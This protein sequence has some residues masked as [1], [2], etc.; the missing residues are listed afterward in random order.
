MKIAVISAAV[1]NKSGSRAPVEL[2]VHLAKL[3]HQ[4]F[5]FAFNT[6]FEKEA[7]NYL[8]QNK[9]QIFILGSSGICGRWVSANNLF[10]KLRTLNPDILSTHCT[11][12]L[13]VAAWFTG[14][15]VVKTYYGLQFFS[16]NAL[17]LK[18]KLLAG[19]LDK[20]IIL[21][22]KIVFK[23][24]H[25][26]VAISKYL[27]SEAE[28]LLG[29]KIAF[30]YIGVDQMPKPK[31]KD[32][33]LVQIK[34]RGEVLILSVSRI[35]PYK[36]FDVLIQA[37]K[38]INLPW[39]LV[40][41]GSYGK[42]SYYKKIRALAD[43]RVVFLRGISDQDL[44]DLYD[45][46]DLYS[47]GGKV[48]E[49]FG[50]PFLEAGLHSKPSVAFEHTVLQEVIIHGKTGYLAKTE[51]EFRDYLKHLM[52]KKKLRQQFGQSALKHAQGFTWEK[53]AREYEK[54]FKKQINF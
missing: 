40:V 10:K 20:I 36:G 46:C 51:A 6:P 25:Q 2:A 34:K 9:V 27:A 14:K 3:K 28:S 39:R 35:V 42:E 29:K 11:F 23:L 5:F 53:C 21:R 4:V 24:S 54:I 38:K 17:S 18:E 16:W 33:K 48:W 30:A 22:E 47:L 44:H 49:G 50:M 37:L 43:K 1:S 13:S 19:I 52:G 31:S 12:P 8:K 15:P 32:R 7:E 26:V 45:Q 41:V